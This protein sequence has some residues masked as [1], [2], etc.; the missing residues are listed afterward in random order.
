MH[1]GGSEAMMSQEEIMEKIRKEHER[2]RDLGISQDREDEYYS[3][4]SPDS[5]DREQDQRAFNKAVEGL[6][7]SAM[8][9][10]FV[11]EVLDAGDGRGSE[12]WTPS[13]AIHDP[14]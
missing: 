11:R 3:N 9:L 10:A 4:L 2:L 8:D 5:D 13:N 14:V 12:F 1:L 6:S 7:L